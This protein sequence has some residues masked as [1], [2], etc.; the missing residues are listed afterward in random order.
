[1]K[2]F[3]N[4]AVILALL[5]QPV[6]AFAGKS[7]SSGGSRPSVSTSRPSTPSVSRPST[8]TPSRPST[9]S[10]KS[11]SSGST[12][13]S[14]RP[15]STSTSSNSSNSR[16]PS[17]TGYSSSLSSSGKKTE[18]RMKYEA[19]TAPKPTYK[20]STGQSKP[21]D[22]ASPQV[23]SVRKTITH[24]R[25]VTY[26]N[27]CSGF[28]GGFYSHPVYY[29]DFFSPFLMG[30]I[31]SDAVNSHD[32]ALWMYHHQADMDAARYAE[33]LKRDA[34]LQAEIDQLK[35]QKVPVD[36]SYVPA[37]MKDNPDLMYNKDFVDAS[38]NETST[39]EWDEESGSGAGEVLLIVFLV[40]LGL[41]GV[42]AVFYLLFVKEY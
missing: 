41:F 11:Y 30:W 42:M 23:S 40:I 18:S 3:A 9:P 27:R 7:Y 25:Y 4:L 13:S 29:N 14:T 32:R 31:L 33:L 15:S 2:K 26:D 22:A 17:G 10:G 20:T 36:G 38:Y 8:P 34:K 6:T 16:K 1:M 5:L 35:A 21:L 37:Q 19:A 28:Y 24:E 12:S 39:E